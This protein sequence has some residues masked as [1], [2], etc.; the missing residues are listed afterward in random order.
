VVITG[1]SSSQVNTWNW[2][3]NGIQQIE[4]TQQINRTFTQ[5][6]QYLLQLV[7]TDIYSQ[8]PLTVYNSVVATSNLAVL[9]SALDDMDP[10]RVVEL[11]GS[12]DF[13]YDGKGIGVKTPI[14]STSFNN[15]GFSHASGPDIIFS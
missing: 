12:A 7:A 13:L 3:I 2:F 5:K 6:G 9:D 4:T 15:A 8:G 11:A 10:N 1:V 14:Y